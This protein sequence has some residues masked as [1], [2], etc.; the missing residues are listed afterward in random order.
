MQET[1]ETQV[2]SLGR[3]PG[4]GHCNPL[5]YS[6]LENPMDRGAWPTTQSF[7]WQRVRHKWSNLADIHAPFFLLDRFLL[8]SLL[9]V[10]FLPFFL[11]FLL[12]SQSLFWTSLVQELMDFHSF[13]WIKVCI[14]EF[15]YVSLN[16]AFIEYRKE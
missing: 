1:Q 2:R 5:K 8:L 15:F 3:S 14:Y 16:N 7:R 12:Y 4:G 6:C 13:W 10:I 11:T 9:L